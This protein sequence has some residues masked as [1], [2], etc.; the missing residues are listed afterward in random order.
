MTSDLTADRL[1]AYLALAEELHFT[2]AAARLHV[3]QPALTKRIQQLEQAIG[4]QLFARSKRMVRL[5]PAGEA[6]LGAA[7]Q[8]LSALESLTATAARLEAGEIGRLRVGFTPSAPHHLLPDIVRAFRRAHPDVDCQLTE[9]GSD[10][11]VQRLLDGDLDVGILRP[12][13][14]VPAR[15]VCRRLL[16][17]RFVAVLPRD[18]RLAR[19]RSVALADLAADPFVLVARRVVRAVHDQILA[20]CL[21]AGFTPLIVQEATHIHSVVGLVASGMG[22]SILPA[23]AASLGLRDVVC[24][25]LRHVPLTTVVAV[26]TLSTPVTSAAA[27]FVSTVLARR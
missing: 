27:A 11:Q 4:V 1:A 23:S 2:R 9:M 12:P 8:A 26:A 25:P 17:E 6:L 14:V 21:A 15:L 19:R 24:K 7:R 3:A 13:A 10:D 5:T 22:V 18:H 20:A 16:E